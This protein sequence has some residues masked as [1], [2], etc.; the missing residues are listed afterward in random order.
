MYSY[1][2]RMKS[3]KKGMDDKVLGGY[4][5]KNKFREIMASSIL[6]GKPQYTAHTLCFRRMNTMYPLRSQ[7]YGVYVS[8]TKIIQVGKI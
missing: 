8:L 5:P 3:V 1:W 2:I 7:K 4:L 6:E